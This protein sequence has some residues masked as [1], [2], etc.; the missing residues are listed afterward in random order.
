V[1]SYFFEI[2]ERA[3]DRYS[4]ILVVYQSG[5][6]RVI[7]RANRDFRS[8]RK[9]AKAAEGLKAIVK[10]AQ[11]VRAF[12]TAPDHSFQILR[13]V[14][15]LPVGSP[16][17]GGDFRS[18]PPEAVATPGRPDAT[19]AAGSG[20]DGPQAPSRPAGTTPTAESGAEAASAQEAPAQAAPAD[21]EASTDREASTEDE[22]AARPSRARKLQTPRAPRGRGAAKATT[23]S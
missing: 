23:R 9:A 22:P 15:P 17:T 19:Q 1:N 11:I 13:D 4:W 2:V 12:P 7:A 16:G 18:P 5:R 20:D 6:R 3:F 10:G 14:L 21:E 8:A